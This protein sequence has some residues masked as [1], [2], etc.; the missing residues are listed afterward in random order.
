MP[1]TQQNES[2]ISDFL[3]GLIS[4]CHESDDISASF[5]RG[6]QIIAELQGVWTNLSINQHAFSDLEKMTCSNEAREL[7]GKLDSNLFEIMRYMRQPH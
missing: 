6:M 5:E 3:I 7:I 1:S 2:F 4:E